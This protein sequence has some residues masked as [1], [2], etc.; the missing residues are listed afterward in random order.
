[1]LQYVDYR[2]SDNDELVAEVNYLADAAAILAEIG[3]GDILSGANIN[4]DQADKVEELLTVLGKMSYAK[5]HAD[6]YMEKY[7]LT[8]KGIV[9]STLSGK[10]TIINPII[11]IIKFFCSFY[12]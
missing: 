5:Y 12:Y 9:T 10:N 4:Y 7:E 8:I 2:Q 11:I 1:M 3:L 6:T